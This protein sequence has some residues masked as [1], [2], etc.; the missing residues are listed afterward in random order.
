MPALRTIGVSGLTAVLL[1]WLAILTVQAESLLLLENGQTPEIPP[2]DYAADTRM[3]NMPPLETMVIKTTTQPGQAI[4]QLSERELRLRAANTLGRTLERELGVHNLSYGPAVGQVVIRGM[5]GP[6]VRVMQNGIGTHDASGMSPDHPIAA[7]T[8]LADRITVYRGPATL[9]FGSNAVGGMVDI[10]HQ[11]IPDKIPQNGFAGHAEF[12]FDH[13]PGE[14]AGM[15]ALDMGKN[16]FAVHL[17]YFHRAGG[18]THIPGLALDEEAIVEQFQVQPTENSKGVIQ[19]T[20]TQS[21]GGSAGISLVGD[22]GYVGGSYHELVKHYGVPPGVPGHSSGNRSEQEAVRI[23]MQ[24]RRY[25]LE[26]LWV[27]PWP[28]IPAIEAKLSHIDYA[29]DES[30][31]GSAFTHFRNQVWESRL[32]ISHQH[33]DWL[34]GLA[35][36]QWQDRNFFAAGLETF[37]P[38]SRIGSLGFFLT[39]TLMLT[40]HVSLELGARYDHQTTT[41]KDDAVRI[42]GVVAPLPLPDQLRFNT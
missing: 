33:A 38:A 37:T 16:L 41:P 21:Q 4:R 9:R 22:A 25:D 42:P 32:E 29:H 18:N 5:S 11:R 23:A 35:G 27:T 3:E 28:F 26:G 12:R 31:R 19:N 20:R 7:E 40:D 10:K 17:D 14:K 39:E 24:Q 13:N 6:R 34:D 8:L 36:L 15:I 2:R 1:A 30:D